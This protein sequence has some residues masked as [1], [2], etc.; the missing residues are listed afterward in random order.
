[1]SCFMQNYA[2][3]KGSGKGAQCAKGFKPDALKEHAR[4]RWPEKLGGNPNRYCK[5]QKMPGKFGLRL[6]FF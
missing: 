3:G 5:Q 6:S 1:M 4:P 2:G